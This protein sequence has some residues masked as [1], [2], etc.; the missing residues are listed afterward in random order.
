MMFAIKAITIQIAWYTIFIMVQI[1]LI[2]SWD[3]SVSLIAIWE[4]ITKT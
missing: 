3:T 1:K 4:A 2:E